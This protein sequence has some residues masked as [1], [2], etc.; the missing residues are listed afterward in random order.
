VLG[1]DATARVVVVRAVGDAGNV[2]TGRVRTR[3][4]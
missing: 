2:T 4:R 1:L 3:A